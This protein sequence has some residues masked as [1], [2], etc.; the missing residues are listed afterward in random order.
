MTRAKDWLQ[1]SQELKDI[2]ELLIDKGRFSWSCFTSQQASAAA[3]KAI[4]ASIDGSTFGD[5]LIALL[6]EIKEQKEVPAEIK[7]ACQNLN[8]YFKTSRDLERKPSGTPE[9]Y[10]TLDDAKKALNETL[11]IIRYAYQEAK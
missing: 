7:K 3:L 10:F 4:L 9:Q 5:N 1:Y 11:A 8:E 6:R 2:A